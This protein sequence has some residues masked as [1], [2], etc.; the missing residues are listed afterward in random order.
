MQALTTV[1]P[2]AEIAFMQNGRAVTWAE[3]TTEDLRATLVNRPQTPEAALAR[4]EWHRRMGQA[5]KVG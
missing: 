5:C 1:I 4:V 3:V 2:N